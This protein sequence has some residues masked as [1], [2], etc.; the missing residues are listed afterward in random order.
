MNTDSANKF[1]L[2]N[3][4]NRRTTDNTNF[5]P[6]LT[7]DNLGGFKFNG[8]A[9]SSTTPAVPA[10]PAAQIGAAATEDWTSTANG[11]KFT[12][13]AIKKG[14]ITDLEIISGASDQST[15]RSDAFS[16]RDSSDITKVNISSTKTQF[17]TPVQFPVYTAA[18]ANALGSV[19]AGS[20]VTGTSYT[21][22]SVGTTDFTLIGAGSNTVGVIFT[23]TGPGTGTGTASTNVVGQ[24][25]CI[26]NSSSGGNPNGMMAFWDTT[27]AR[28]SYIHDHTAV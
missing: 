16:F 20:F 28:W 4:V 13:T 22:T 11:A 27:H 10:G 3:L 12:F 15:F 23:A 25:I 26:S 19:N 14:T 6:T 18:Q 7:N 5:T 24:Q 2:F 9:Y 1:P 21:I 8:N 17:Y